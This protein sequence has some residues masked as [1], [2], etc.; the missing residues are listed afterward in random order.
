MALL[1]LADSLDILCRCLDVVIQCWHGPQALGWAGPHHK[2]AAWICR[3]SYCMQALRLTVGCFFLYDLSIIQDCFRSLLS[4][5]CNWVLLPSVI[6]N[7]AFHFLKVKDIPAPHL[8]W[9]PLK[10]VQLQEHLLYG[11]CTCLQGIQHHILLLS[12]SHGPSFQM[13]SFCWHTQISSVFQTSQSCHI[14]I[15][16]H[17]WSLKPEVCWFSRSVVLGT[18]DTQMDIQ[19]RPRIFL[20]IFAFVFA[21]CS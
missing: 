2:L 4:F 21:S 8:P 1:L 13:I 10:H 15:P 20:V 7:A 5:F 9:H 17:L 16:H 6:M 11:D 18:A 14:P 19:A 12:V 3:T